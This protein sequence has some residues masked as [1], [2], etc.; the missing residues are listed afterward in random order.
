MKK[1][2]SLLLAVGMAASAFAFPQKEVKRVSTLV[3]ETKRV[4]QTSEKQSSNLLPEQA[5]FVANAKMYN[6]QAD[7]TVVAEAP[8]EATIISF[9]EKAGKDTLFYYESYSSWLGGW[10]VIFSDGSDYPANCIKLLIA[11]N[12]K[13]LRGVYTTKN[14]NAA[15]SNVSVMIDK[16]STLK[17]TIDSMYLSFTP[18][19]KGYQIEGK[20]FVNNSAVCVTLS[21]LKEQLMP[22]DTVDIAIP[23]AEIDNLT[24]STWVI[25][26]ATADNKYMASAQV[27]STRI[28]GGYSAAQLDS[29]N[30]YVTIVADN[31][32]IRNMQQTAALTSKCKNKNY[33]IDY[34]MIGTDTVLYNVHFTSPVPAVKDTVEL[35]AHNLKIDGSLIEWGMNTVMISASTN[36]FNMSIW[37]TSDSLPNDN[38]TVENF[39]SSFL[40]FG[41]KKIIGFMDGSVNINA[42]DTTITGYLLGEDIVCYHLNLNFEF[43]KAKDTVRFDFGEEVLPLNFEQSYMGGEYWVRCKQGKYDS[44]LDFY[45]DEKSPVGSYSMLAKQM[46]S[47]YNFIGII[48]GTDTIMIGALDAN[49]TVEKT[50][51]DTI[52]AVTANLLG[53]DTIAYVFTFKASY[54]YVEAAEGS[55]PYDAKSG[56][57]AKT[58]TQN[59]IVG[60]SGEHYASDNVVYFYALAN[61]DSRYTDLTF[62]VDDVIIKGDT[63]PAAGIYTIDY[64]EKPGTVWAS[65]GVESDKLTG[66]FSGFLTQQGISSQGIYF[67]VSGTVTVSYNENQQVK[68]V[69]A[70][71][72]SNGLNVDIVYDAAATAIDNVN[73]DA[74]QPVKVLRNGQVLIFRDGKYFNTVGQIVE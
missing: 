64:S 70:A 8:A 36:E 33:L 19:R 45:A 10:S 56:D 46:P 29:M 27:K 9:N 44:Q 17:S 40:A 65:K 59:D 58:Y 18:V 5:A 2:F 4:I 30:S 67:L 57:L 28:L 21:H 48:N 35:V 42:K 16:D 74:A 14:L 43:P 63:M 62:F 32:T 72:N 54:N 61:D 73:T 38:Y 23:M 15:Q 50:K 1:S 25:K 68:V 55:L 60:F 22:K 53:E 31:D 49:M 34:T 12:A 13:E 39:Q 37:L 66:S 51:V 47:L 20:F 69:I 24:D 26:G 41:E 71:K 3:G 6:S 11:D 52:F 7:Q